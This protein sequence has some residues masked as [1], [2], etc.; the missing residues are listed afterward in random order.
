MQ[1]VDIDDG[2]QAYGFAT[3]FVPFQ[4]SQCHL[5]V[6][7]V[8]GRLRAIAVVATVVLHHQ[9]HVLLGEVLVACVARD[10]RN[11][12]QLTPKL[13]TNAIPN[14]LNN[15]TSQFAVPWAT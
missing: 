14:I 7:F 4:K 11:L 3:L 2:T 6:N 1:I 13:V 12:A 15:A 5:S 8:P 10:V 9:F